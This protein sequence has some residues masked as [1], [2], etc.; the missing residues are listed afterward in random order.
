MVF[1]KSVMFA[2][3]AGQAIAVT[4]M[5]GERA[6]VYG[7]PRAASARNQS[8]RVADAI[9]SAESSRGKDIGMWRPDPAGPQGPMQVSEAAATDVGGGDRFDLTQNR[10]IGRAYLSQLFGRY[11]NW[12]DAIAAYNWGLGKMDAWVRA[13]RPSDR[14]VTGVAAYLQRVL[15]ESGLC[16]GSE[17][18]HE[19]ERP[20]AKQPNL[21]PPDSL[22]YEACSAPGPSGGS[23]G[24]G[25]GPSRF[26]K[27]LDAA[28]QLALQRAAQSR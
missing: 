8:G 14:F 27:K 15:H 19:G 3:L 22:V 24:S 21:S 2:L 5:A 1:T 11:R 20:I 23:T 18:V 17:V 16:N 26:Y 6:G 10:A 12:P 13:G 9:E 4:A 28:L 7:P 25:V